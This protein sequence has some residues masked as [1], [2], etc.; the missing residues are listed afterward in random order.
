MTTICDRL[1]HPDSAT[2]AR[3]GAGTSGLYERLIGGRAPS[4]D[5]EVSAA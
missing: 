5:L 2:A 3:A 4:T 1:R